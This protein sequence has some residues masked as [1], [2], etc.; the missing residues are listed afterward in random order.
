MKFRLKSSHGFTTPIMFA[1]FT[2]VAILA[3][4]G[5]INLIQQNQSASKTASTIQ[6]NTSQQ[7]AD[8]ENIW[9]YATV[10]INS[11]GNQIPG[12]ARQCNGPTKLSD[13]EAASADLDAEFQKYK[14]VKVGRPNLY[15]ISKDTNGNI[16]KWKDPDGKKQCQQNLPPNSEA[17]NAAIIQ[18]GDFTCTDVTKKSLGYTI[19]AINP[20]SKDTFLATGV[21]DESVPMVKIT[22][23][24]I[25]VFVD[26][27]GNNA[28]A[29]YYYCLKASPTDCAK[30]DLKQIGKNKS[31]VNIANRTITFNRLCGNGGSELKE[32]CNSDG[33]D[34][35]H[36]TK[37]YRISLFE[38]QDPKSRILREAA[39]Y[40]SHYYPTIVEPPPVKVPFLTTE[41]P[42]LNMKDIGEG[43]T[44][45]K[46]TLEGRNIRGGKNNSDSDTFN[47]YS[48]RVIGV[49]NEY[50]SDPQGCIYIP[51]SSD[52]K[53]ATG[54]LDILLSHAAPGTEDNPVYLTSGQYAIQIT[55]GIGDN[56][57]NPARC[58]EGAFT[59]YTI[60]FTIGENGSGSMGI[61]VRD[62]NGKE[63]APNV[64]PGPS[65]APICFGKNK[66]KDGYCTAI[67]TALGFTIHTDP[68]RFVS[69]IFTIV[70][71]IGGIA[72]ILFFIQAGY[73]LMTSAGNKEKVAAS[74]EQITAAIMGLLFIILSIT[75]LEFIGI[76]ILHIPGIGR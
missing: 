75:I 47:D 71:S 50:K 21:P 19:C 3:I 60:P 18:D 68:A 22:I 25:P 27:N 30:D 56:P 72:A 15:L 74:R 31:T 53:T 10:E 59:L 5:I 4:A 52:P 46:V 12:G 38:K 41:R 69:D 62:P 32:N 48:V 49:D 14:D 17:P 6:S 67:P 24:D 16:I 61:P 23:T 36:S 40:V 70:L 8:G 11:S 39:F 43:D 42:D 35:F 29:N 44:H 76:N 73:R 51:A 64:S 20:E 2:L 54:S 13:I 66:D 55:D 37:V 63:T 65:P 1:G 9:Y 7:I 26:E 33:S 34:F 28:N 45:I 58:T 57:K